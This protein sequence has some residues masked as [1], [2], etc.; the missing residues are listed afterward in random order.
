M[1]GNV[2]ETVMGA[3]VLVVAA[4]FLL[5]AY[6]TSELRAVSGYPVSADFEPGLYPTTPPKLSRISNAPRILIPRWR[7]RGFT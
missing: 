2:I 1:K 5:F 3:V 6:R 7:K 4:L